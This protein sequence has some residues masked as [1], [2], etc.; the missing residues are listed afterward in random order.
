[1]L[2]QGIAGAPSNLIIEL[3]NLIIQTTETTMSAWIG[4]DWVVLSH[5]QCKPSTPLSL[6]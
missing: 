5:C 6:T 4:K 1:M 3:Y 2:E